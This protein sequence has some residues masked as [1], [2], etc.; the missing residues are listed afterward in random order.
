MVWIAGAD[1]ARGGWIVAL[2]AVGSETIVLRLARTLS[3]IPTWPESPAMLGLDIPIGLPEE[4]T[5][6]G[7]ACDRL[8]RRLLG[9]RGTTI[10]SAP[11]RPAL[12]ARTFQEALDRNRRSSPHR[13]G[14]SR[15]TF[16]LLPK[17]READAFVSPARQAHVFEVHPELSFFEMNGGQPVLAPKKSEAGRQARLTLL[18]SVFGRPL[19]DVVEVSR[20]REVARDDVLDALAV[21]FTAERAHFGRAVRIPAEP[22]TDARGLRMEIVR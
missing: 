4:A 22:A 7:R 6:G 11:S 20:Q 10:F 16:H 5:P 14:L 2:R 13:I 18:E 12:E 17:I 9:P 1:G 15:Q 8:A 19:G 3:E 21:L